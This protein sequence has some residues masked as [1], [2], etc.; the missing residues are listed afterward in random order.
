MN[1]KHA[2]SEKL[3]ALVWYMGSA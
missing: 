3:S 2:I 1:N